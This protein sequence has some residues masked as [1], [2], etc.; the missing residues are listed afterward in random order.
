MKL[1]SLLLILLLSLFSLPAFAQDDGTHTITLDGFS[2]RYND[3]HAQN[4]NILRYPG[5]PVEG[6]GAGFSDAANTMFNLYNALPAPESPLDAVIGIRLYSMSDL[7]QYDFMQADVDKL[8]AILSGDA[9]LSG[10]QT[11]KGGAEALPFLPT[12]IHGQQLRARVEII[13][14]PEVQGVSYL[15]LSPTQDAIEPFDISSFVYVFQ[16]ISADGQHYVSMVVKL[17]APPLFP[18]RETVDMGALSREWDS[19]LQQG[20]QTLEATPADAFAPSLD[21]ISAVIESFAFSQA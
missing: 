13:K 1:R 19:Y 12:L 17:T 14:T 16:G 8:Q 15:T 11:S 2:F 10:Y 18:G 6:A 21:S 3:A 20:A 4:V 7:A 9:D 5:D